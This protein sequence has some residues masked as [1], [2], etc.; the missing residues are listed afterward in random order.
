[1]VG[2]LARD[3]FGL[4]EIAAMPAPPTDRAGLRERIAAAMY[5]AEYPGFEWVQAHDGDR[6]HVLQHADAVL[7]V[8]PPAADQGAAIE[9]LAAERDELRTAWDSLARCT[10]EDAEALFEVGRLVGLSLGERTV[11]IR[12]AI[13]AIGAELRR[14]ADEEQQPETQAGPGGTTDG[15][16]AECELPHPCPTFT[17]ATTDRDPL[18]TWDPADDD[19]TA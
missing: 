16:C 18:A 10:A 5:E 13:E 7:S 15:L 2:S 6:E 11:S 1:M 17:W 3:G 8:L 12:A 4:D 14:M 9:R 19:A